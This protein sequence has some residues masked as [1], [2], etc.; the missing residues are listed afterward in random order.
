MTIRI[1]FP[2]VKLDAVPEEEIMY[3][4]AVTSEIRIDAYCVDEEEEPHRETFVFHRVMGVSFEL[5]DALFHSE[6]EKL[7]AHPLQTGNSQIQQRIL[8]IEHSDWIH[9]VRASK[10]ETGHSDPSGLKHYVVP[11]Y[12]G[13]W[14][15]LAFECRRME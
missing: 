15:I 6:N 1:V 3:S 7:L 14:Q 13:V 8:E 11:V 10:R 12:E 2:D 4:C 5:D 9:A